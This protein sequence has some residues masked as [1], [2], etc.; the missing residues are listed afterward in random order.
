MNQQQPPLAD[1]DQLS[2]EAITERIRTLDSDGLEQVR[3]YEQQHANR[4]AVAM[5]VDRRAE[6][7]ADGAE[8]TQGPARG[9]AGA[10]GPDAPRDQS[11]TTDAPPQNPPSQGDPTNPSQPR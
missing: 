5:A 2:V 6:Q 4:P 7:L 10:S 11:M 3:D 9:Y 1:Y 8:P